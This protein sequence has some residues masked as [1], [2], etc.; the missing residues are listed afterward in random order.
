MANTIKT[1]TLPPGPTKRIWVNKA[2][3]PQFGGKSP[4]SPVWWVE[5]EG[6]RYSGFWVWVCGGSFFVYEPGEGDGPH[7]FVETRMEVV[8]ETAVQEAA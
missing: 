8:I 2:V 7:A 3:L 5:C 6:V 1:T 4:T